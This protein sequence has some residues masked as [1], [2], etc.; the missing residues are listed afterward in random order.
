[1]HIAS[2]LLASGKENTNSGILISN[3]V[4]LNYSL[5]LSTWSVWY[6]DFPRFCWSTPLLFS[7]WKQSTPFLFLYVMLLFPQLSSANKLQVKDS[8]HIM[9]WGFE[10]FLPFCTPFKI[11]YILR[12]PANTHFSQKS[13]PEKPYFL[14]IS[15]D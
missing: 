6:P 14:I 1:M 11:C 8:T 13:R 5:N 3:L 4:L 15:I 9:L 10:A 2:I 7:V 12:D